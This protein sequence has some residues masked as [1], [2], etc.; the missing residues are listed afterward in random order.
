MIKV[1]VANEDIKQNRDCLQFLANDKNL[2]VAGAT[3]GT[4]ALQKYLEI[5]PNVF[6]LDSYFTDI[7]YTDI[8][9][10]ICITL[11]E[12]RK[13]N[14]IL[15]VNNNMEQLLLQDVEKVYKILKK[16]LNLCNLYNTINTMVKEAQIIELKEVEVASLLLKLNFHIGS[17]G[18]RYLISAIIYC[19][20]FPNALYSLKRVICNTCKTIFCTSRNNKRS[21][22]MCLKPSKSFWNLQ[23]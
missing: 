1:L 21:N 4:S 5:K 6:I 22:K 8:L 17:E 13:C 19:Y 10:R 9:D 14:T 3:N 18:S 16:P 15:T 12:K 7:C 20:Y 23:Y 11:D 2:N